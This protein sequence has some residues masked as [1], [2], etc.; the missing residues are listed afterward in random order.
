MDG[1][2]LRYRVNRDGTYTLW[3]IGEDGV[4]QGGQLVRVG[5]KAPSRHWWMGEDAIWPQ[6]ASDAEIRAWKEAQQEKQ[7][8]Q[9]RSG[10]ASLNP[11]MM[12]RYGLLPTGT[13]AAT[14]GTNSGKTP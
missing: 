14:N 7:S 9:G 4:D 3:S 12:K 11:E 13:E 2:P 8:K 1:Q 6:P 10:N 5:K